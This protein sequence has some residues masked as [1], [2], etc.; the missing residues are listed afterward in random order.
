MPDEIKKKL[1]T[2]KEILDNPEGYWI[3]S[4]GYSVAFVLNHKNAMAFQASLGSAESIDSED[5]NNH[6]IV[7]LKAGAFEMKMISQ[8]R[9]MAMKMST[10]IG[11]DVDKLLEEEPE[12]PF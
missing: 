9:Y 5:Y 7:P 2:K 8:K 3:V 6:V 4:F 1:P 10:L 11:I 12:I